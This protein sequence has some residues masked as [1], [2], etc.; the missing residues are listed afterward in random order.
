MVLARDSDNIY[1]LFAVRRQ[2]IAI[3]TNEWRAQRPQ[4][5]RPA[6]AGIDS[7][8]H[9]RNS[10]IHTRRRAAV[11]EYTFAIG[12]PERGNVGV[13]I[14][15]L[16]RTSNIEFASSIVSNVRVFTA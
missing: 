16:V 11:E 7:V 8:E 3:G 4:F 14:L 2:R 6:A 5:L 1:Q 15:L 13:T 9:R 12:R 10:D